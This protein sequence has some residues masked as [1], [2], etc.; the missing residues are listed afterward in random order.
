MTSAGILIGIG[1]ATVFVYFG[2][3]YLSRQRFLRGRRATAIPV[4]V[5]DLPVSIDRCEAEN[6]LRAIGRSFAVKPEILRLDDSFAA[7]AAMDSWMLGKGQE[8]LEQWLRSN[9]VVNLQRKP[10]TIRDLIVA[11]LQFDH[12]EHA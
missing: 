1:F 2:G 6:I 10:Q 11:A 7:L 12:R 3:R 9:G 8:D 5:K 4:I